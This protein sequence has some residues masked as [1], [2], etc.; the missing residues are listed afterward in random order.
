MRKSIVWALA[1]VLAAACGS[2][3][4]E[5]VPITVDV[6][7]G[8][9]DAEQAS[10]PGSSGSGS[11]EVIPEPDEPLD[12]DT[13]RIGSQVWERTLPMTTGQCFVYEDDGTLPDSG[14]AWGTLDGDDDIRFS[15]NYNQDGTF[16]AEVSDSERLYWIAGARSA[17]PDDL[18]VE[19]DFDA[20][21]ITGE[22]VFNSLTTGETA[23]GSFAFQC[24]P[25][26]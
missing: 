4:T 21:T 17:N 13:I 10:D 5:F 7:E 18:T 16:E 25:E 3:E 15:A 6:G 20:L 11:S 12:M 14:T 23:H 1:L 26:E 22:G 9:G 2:V 19:L 8:S 24:E